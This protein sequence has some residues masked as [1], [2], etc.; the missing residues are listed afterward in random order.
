MSRTGT[1]QVSS[2]D[3]RRN[4]TASQPGWVGAAAIGPGAAA[5]TGGEQQSPGT[6][7]PAVRAAVGVEAVAH[8]AG[9]SRGS[10]SPDL[11]AQHAAVRSKNPSPSSL[12]LSHLKLNQDSAWTAV[13]TMRLLPKAGSGFPAWQLPPGMLRGS[14][15][16]CCPASGPAAP[17][18]PEGIGMCVCRGGERWG[19]AAAACNGWPR[20]WKG[21]HRGSFW[22]SQG[23]G[24]QCSRPLE[25][26]LGGCKI[27][28]PWRK[29]KRP[30][31]PARH[32]VIIAAFRQ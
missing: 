11:G 8:C 13:K 2:L 15:A 19:A 20:G 18:P 6:G 23:I 9:L 7:G 17:N 26:A 12:Q 28:A 29:P 24:Q 16:S 5:R 10:L 1:L 21:A 3:K 31:A 30:P 27:T 25:K 22:W 14:L 4:A 32:C